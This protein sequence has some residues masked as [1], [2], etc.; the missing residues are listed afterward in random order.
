MGQ[1]GLMGGILVALWIWAGGVPVD[2]RP[3]LELFSLRAS[4]RLVAHLLQRAPPERGKVIEQVRHQEPP[5]RRERVCFVIGHHGVA[6]NAR[7]SSLRGDVQRTAC[8]ADLEV[9][10]PAPKP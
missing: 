5:D 2:C 3:V 6:L 7:V 8:P 1:P 10:A 4:H 9:G